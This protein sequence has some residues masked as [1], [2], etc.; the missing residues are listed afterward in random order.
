MRKELPKLLEDFFKRE[1]S[2]ID[3]DGFY[4]IIGTKNGDSSINSLFFYINNKIDNYK[5]RRSLNQ[6]Y[7]A[8]DILKIVIDN[9]QNLSRKNIRRKLKKLYERCDRRKENEDDSSIYKELTI[10]GDMILDLEEIL[11]KKDNNQYN[12]VIFIVEQTRNL[13]YL[14]QTFYHFPEYVN[15]H[16]KDEKSIFYNILNKYIKAIEQENSKDIHY[17]EKVIYIIEKQRN[18]SLTNKDKRCCAKLIKD[19]LE[20]LNTS[21]SN[22]DK[23]INLL[24]NIEDLVLNDITYKENFGELVSKY[25]IHVGFDN[26][27]ITELSSYLKPIIINDNKFSYVD[28]YIIT[29]DDTSAHEIDDG[30]SI[31]KLKNGNYLLGVHISSPLSY[32]PYNSK[33]VIEA[34]ERGSSIYLDKNVKLSENTLYDNVIPMF[35]EVFSVFYASLIQGEYKYAKS[36]Y[37]EIDSHASVVNKKFLK[38]VIKNSKQCSYKEV[39]DILEHGSDNE[40][41]YET[42]KLLDEVA[43]KLRENDHSKE[44]YLDIKDKSINPS[45]T[46]VG[47]SRSEK[48]INAAMMLTGKEVAD[49]FA[50]ESKFP[51]L[52]RVH[53]IE[54]SDVVRLGEELRKISNTYEK[55]K[56]NVLYNTLLSI[57]PK[58]KYGLSGSHEGLGLEHY[59]HC[60]SPLRRAA[61]LVVEHSLDICYFS[62]PTDKDI[63][64]LE[65]NIKTCKNIINNKNE[66]VDLFI[67]ELVKKKVKKNSKM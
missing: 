57:Y 9:H 51:T 50:V 10:V 63:Y 6:L 7:N 30:L 40:R 23:K 36:Y 46:K 35:P 20:E 19:A 33:V 62:K 13:S 21:D 39:N 43:Y 29:I 48:I 24:S 27:L 14:E 2:N 5:K 38:T 52:Y 34:I 8:F 54:N 65:K 12:F 47:S 56:F 41:L 15:V 18:F 42:V 60:T 61:D 66:D 45:M 26:S 28:D 11:K 3:I 1:Y 49:Y 17:Y 58:A 22:Y 4:N 44:L 37:F 53:S 31:K 55:E 67:D 16:D 25:D 64:T 32:I 59:C